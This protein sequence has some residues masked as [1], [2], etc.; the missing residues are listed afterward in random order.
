MWL[1]MHVQLVSAKEGKNNYAPHS[2]GLV[3]TT[4]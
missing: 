2:Q 4:L 3:V 1:T